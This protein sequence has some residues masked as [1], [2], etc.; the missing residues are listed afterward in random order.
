MLFVVGIERPGSDSEAFGVVVPVFES[1][2]YGCVSASDTEAGVLDQAKDAIL[3]M[4]EQLSDDGVPLDKLAV[5][6]VDYSQHPEF[7]HVD[8]WVGLDVDLSKIGKQQRLNISLSGGLIA[9]LD[10]FVEGS[11]LYRDRSHFLAVA[12]DNEMNK[13]R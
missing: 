2:G 8:Y 13:E 3:S 11:P 5:G 4:A 1:V 12:A 10:A 7:D 6:F 9:R